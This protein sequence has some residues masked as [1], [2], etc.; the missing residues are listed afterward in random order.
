[1][2]NFLYYINLIM[3]LINMYEVMS[4]QQKMIIIKRIDFYFFILIDN[5]KIIMEI[6]M[7][8]SY[9]NLFL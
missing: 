5:D 9:H 8:I 7:L 6:N 2:N 3:I 4:Y 1:M